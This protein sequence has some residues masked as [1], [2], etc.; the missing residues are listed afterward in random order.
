MAIKSWNPKTNILNFDDSIYETSSNTWVRDY[1][2]PQQQIPSPQESYEV[3]HNQ[4]SE[5]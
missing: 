5:L 1:S 4:S 2:Y 3:Y